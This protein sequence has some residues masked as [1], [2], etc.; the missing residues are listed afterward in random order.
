MF[1]ISTFEFCLETFKYY[2]TYLLHMEHK[3]Y[4][5]EIVNELLNGENY[6]RGI[7]KNDSDIDIYIETT[8]KKIKEEIAL[9]D[10]KISVKIGE[11]NKS[12]LLIRE[13]ERNHV[14][15]KGVEIYY[16][17]NKFFEDD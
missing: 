17:H 3:D 13:I 12:N 14:I 6:I 7:A 4:K 9:I 8:N 2:G 15:L 11:Y 1:L 16:E 10:S 5:V